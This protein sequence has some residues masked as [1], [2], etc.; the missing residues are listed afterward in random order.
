M[1]VIENKEHNAAPQY[2]KQKN[3]AKYNLH[4]EKSSPQLDIRLYV[5][6]GVYIPIAK[7]ANLKF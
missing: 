6:T 3:R 7:A 4:T 2:I 1:R 5:I